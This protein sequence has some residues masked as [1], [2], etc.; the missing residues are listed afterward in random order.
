VRLDTKLHLPSV[1]DYLGV[2]ATRFFGAGHR[3]VR[4]LLTDLVVGRDDDGVGF[5]CATA[6]VNYPTDWS[7][8]AGGPLRPHLSTIDAL[9]FG[10]QLA[11]ACLTHRYRLDAEQRRAM[12]L[13]RVDMKAGTRP[14]EDGLH[15][16]PVAAALHG[17]TPDAGSLCGH[18]SVVACEVGPMKL[19]CV[20]EHGVGPDDD[21]P[22]IRYRS[23]DALLGPAPVR[24]YGSGFAD[25]RQLVEDVTLDLRDW[26]ARAQATVQPTSATGQAEGIEGR[27][28]PAVSM[29]DAFVISLQLGQVLLYELDRLDRASS[30]T[31]W[32][33]RTTIETTTSRRPGTAPFPVAAELT[34]C[35][36]LTVRGATWR[37]ADVVADVQNIRT[38]CAVAHELPRDAAPVAIPGQRSE[39]ATAARP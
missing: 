12:W 10:V 1:D 3:R 20:V 15:A 4:H 34:E 17:T 14:L 11:E 25:R 38:T 33:R 26:S 39:T 22:S 21:P 37:T 5:A 31:L 32:M 29:V 19:R 8:K 18:V 28:Q 27:Y 24:P 7:R 30:N 23:A 9:L 13:R 16:F 2:S 6:G 36:L 35:K